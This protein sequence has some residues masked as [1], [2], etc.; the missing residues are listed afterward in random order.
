MA[1]RKRTEADIAAVQEQL[2]KSPVRNLPAPE[3]MTVDMADP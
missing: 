1:S 3:Y 2:R